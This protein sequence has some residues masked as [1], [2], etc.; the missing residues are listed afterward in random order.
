MD[1]AL[2]WANF[3]AASAS[4]APTSGHM[5]GI[6]LSQ[7]FVDGQPDYMLSCPSPTAEDNEWASFFPERAS[8]GPKGAV[9]QSCAEA[10]KADGSEATKIGAF[11]EAL[12]VAN[13]TVNIHLQP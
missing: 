9:S 11:P 3:D 4:I 1:S 7:S 13:S 6:D 8:I 12:T 2:T 5:P 10:G